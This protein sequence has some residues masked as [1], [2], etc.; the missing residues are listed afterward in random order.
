MR[1]TRVVDVIEELNG[2]HCNTDVYNSWIDKEE[3]KKNQKRIWHHSC[4]ATWTG[5]YDAVIATVARHQFK[6]MGIDG[7][8]ALGKENHVLYDIK[9]IFSAELVDGRLL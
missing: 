7:I 2:Y 6:Q 3:S 5:E 9:Y 8:C 4:R 1:N